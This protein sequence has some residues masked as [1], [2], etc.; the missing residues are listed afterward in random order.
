[1]K[2]KVKLIDN[3]IRLFPL[4]RTD[5]KEDLLIEDSEYD[6]LVFEANETN[7]EL[8]IENG[9]LVVVKEKKVLTL[10]EEKKNKKEELKQARDAYK[11][12]QII[13]KGNSV[14]YF[15]KEREKNGF[16][17]FNLC[18]GLNDYTVEDFDKYKSIIEHIIE[19]YN[20]YNSFIKQAKNKEELDKIQFTF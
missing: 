10:E 14:L 7:S 2:L 18:W 4:S 5:I 15:E 20:K 11:K 1:M 13:A 19:K 3:E 8:K 17:Y 12:T 16:E 6:L 9:K